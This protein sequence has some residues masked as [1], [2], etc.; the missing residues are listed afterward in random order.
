MEGFEIALEV[1]FFEFFIKLFEKKKKKNLKYFLFF[2][3]GS[4]TKDYY[5]N[6]RY[7]PSKGFYQTRNWCSSDP[8]LFSPSEKIIN[9][10]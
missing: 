7:L 9:E 1:I 3:S 10:T 4:T 2:V 5:T 8:T 6:L